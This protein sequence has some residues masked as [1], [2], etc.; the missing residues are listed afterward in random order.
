M[1]RLTFV[2]FVLLML[3]AMAA[4][5]HPEVAA[6]PGDVSKVD[7]T[8]KGYL[9]YNDVDIRVEYLWTDPETDKEVTLVVIPARKKQPVRVEVYKAGRKVYEIQ[10][11][12]GVTLKIYS[13]PSGKLMATLTARKSAA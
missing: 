13:R 11:V 10:L 3:W 5:A 6:P 4:H 2:A 8:S 7:T 9:R 12:E 1:K